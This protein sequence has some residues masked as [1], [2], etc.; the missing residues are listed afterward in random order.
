MDVKSSKSVAIAEVKDILSKRKEEG[1]LGY[2]QSQALDNCE[3]FARLNAAKTA[4]LAKKLTEEG[5]ISEG[6]AIKITDVWPTNA[7]TL[8]AIL[9]KDKVEL[10][11]EEI[12]K[13]MKELS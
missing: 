8:R 2:E 5:K 11:E 9:V 7:A 10:S 6:L 3:K 4:A 12:A 13:I 1:E